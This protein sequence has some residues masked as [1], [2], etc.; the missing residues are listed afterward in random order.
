MISSEVF[1][2][3]LIFLEHSE[4]LEI[5]LG[6]LNGFPEPPGFVWVLGLRNNWA[7]RLG[8]VMLCGCPAAT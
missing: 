6:R 1:F 8:A 5:T 4:L 3:S 7:R 2:F